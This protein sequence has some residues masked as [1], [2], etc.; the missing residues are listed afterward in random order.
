MDAVRSDYDIGR[1]TLAI[2]EIEHC[3]RL[4]LLEANTFVA[5]RNDVRW[6]PCRQHCEQV[7]AMHPVEFDL[8][9]KFDRPHR[10][11]KRPIG[12]EKLRIEPACAKPENI[13]TEPESAQHEDALRLER[14]AG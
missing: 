11:R 7:G 1:G 3:P 6:Q 9:A 10:G 4:V 14:D 5:C 13:I 12:A 8:V 2:G